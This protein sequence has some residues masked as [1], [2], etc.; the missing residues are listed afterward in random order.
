MQTIQEVTAPLLELTKPKE[1][2]HGMKIYRVQSEGPF[3]FK[4][5]ASIPFT[6]GVFQGTGDE[7]RQGI[8]LSIPQDAYDSI[9]HLSENFQQQ[10]DAKHPGIAQKWTSS[11]KQSD[12]YAPTLRAKINLKGDR[13]CKFYDMSGQP[14]KAPAE[15][16][17]LEVTA[18]LRL[19]GVY[20]Q[21]KG[22]GLL[23]DVTHLQ[24][25]PAQ[26]QGA[27]PFAV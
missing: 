18:V 6:P 14:A 24:Y 20:V 17:K 1:L 9:A 23:L 4:V 7:E 15:W 10:L 25:D 3:S 22:A 16:R 19:G 5:S 21:S 8:V 26:N 11:L 27:N 12:K 13:E 2:S